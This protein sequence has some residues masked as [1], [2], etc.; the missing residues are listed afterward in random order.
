MRQASKQE[1]A[2]YDAHLKLRADLS[3]FRKQLEQTKPPP[4]LSKTQRFETHLRSWNPSQVKHFQLIDHELEQIVYASK[5]GVTFAELVLKWL[6]TLAWPIGDAPGPDDPGITWVELTI[7]FWLCTQQTILMPLQRGNAT[8]YVDY[9]AISGW[10]PEQC[11]FSDFVHQF[12]QCV[13]RLESLS[14]SNL[15]PARTRQLIGTLYQLGA[16]VFKRGFLHRPMLP[17]TEQ[18]INVLVQYIAENS[19]QGKLNLAP[20]PM[21]PLRE[22]CVVS[23]LQPLLGDTPAMCHQRFQARRSLIRA[24]RNQSAIDNG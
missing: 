2:E 4:I 14:A 22:P 16:G 6:Q 23:Q 18:T 9:A 24:Q 8:E 15:L 21:I 20:L 1:H 10:L 12:Q 19:L 3:Q 17:L 13:L 7:N 5:W 11:Q